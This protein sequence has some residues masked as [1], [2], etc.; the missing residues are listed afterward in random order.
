MKINQG[1]HQIGLTQVFA[2]RQHDAHVDV[3]ALRNVA[4]RPD[5][6]TLVHKNMFRALPFTLLA[7]INSYT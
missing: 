3:V 5:F 7:G 2:R 6:F 4:T 1:M